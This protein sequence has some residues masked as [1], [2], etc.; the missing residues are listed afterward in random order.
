MPAPGGL[1]RPFAPILRC[2]Q[3]RTTRAAWVRMEAGRRRRTPLRSRQ[4]GPRSWGRPSTID[5]AKPVARS[6]A[7]TGGRI[8][9]PPA[10]DLEAVMDAG[11]ITALA[12]LLTALAGLLAEL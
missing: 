5:G 4:P 7:L 9:R 10:R 12:M 11:T 2:P 8:R 3:S 6:A 1:T